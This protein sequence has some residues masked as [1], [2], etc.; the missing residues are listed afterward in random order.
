MQKIEYKNGLNVPENPHIQSK[1]EH[2]TFFLEYC[3]FCGYERLTSF[4]RI[5][6]KK[7]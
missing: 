5:L 3:Q 1:S 4:E 2:Q 7:S 6:R